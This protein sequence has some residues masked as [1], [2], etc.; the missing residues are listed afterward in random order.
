MTKGAQRWNVSAAGPFPAPR[1]PL[2]L[3]SGAADPGSRLNLEAKLAQ[4]SVTV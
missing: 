2:R 1:P 3:E 4:G